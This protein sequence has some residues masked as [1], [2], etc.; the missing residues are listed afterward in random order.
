MKYI[1]NVLFK[2]ILWLGKVIRSICYFIWNFKRRPKQDI[3]N[4]TS[5]RNKE[6]RSNG[7]VGIISVLATLL[8]SFSGVIWGTSSADISNLEKK[9]SHSF[10]R[11][12]E[13]EYLTSN[14]FTFKD[15]L[16]QNIKL[17]GEAKLLSTQLLF[18]L[19]YYQN[20]RLSALDSATTVKSCG[21]STCYEYKEFI[22]H[23]SDFTQRAHMYLKSTK[24]PESQNIFFFYAPRIMSQANLIVLITPNYVKKINSHIIE[25]NNIK[26]TEENRANLEEKIQNIFK[27]GEFTTLATIII[28]YIDLIYECLVEIELSEKYSDYQTKQIYNVQ[29]KNII[30]QID[31]YRP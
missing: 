24:I 27:D 7:I 17:R 13:L 2:V 23:F 29:N 5:L 15:S 6:S 3:E 28:E 11:M 21:L 9:V 19:D 12:E 4:D 26:A 20:M 22:N 31:K 25:I 1:F 18:Q 30:P 10:S 14:N 8:G 16:S